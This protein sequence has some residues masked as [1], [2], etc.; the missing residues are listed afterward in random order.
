LLELSA[1][2]VEV[3]NRVMEPFKRENQLP[4][5]DSLIELSSGSKP[6]ASPH[7]IGLSFSKDIVAM[8]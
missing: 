4:D 6:S 5:L 3:D 8:K 1:L 7:S 2:N